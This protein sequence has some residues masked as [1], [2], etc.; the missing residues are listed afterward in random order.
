MLPMWQWSTKH[1]RMCALAVMSH[2]KFL[3]GSQAATVQSNPLAHHLQSTWVNICT[4]SFHKCVL[5]A[6]LQQLSNIVYDH[7]P[8]GSAECLSA[9]Y[10]GNKQMQKCIP[11]RNMVIPYGDSFPTSAPKSLTQMPSSLIVKCGFPSFMPEQSRY[12][13][14]QSR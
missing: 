5:S 3:A 6:F 8:E 11:L 4:H 13:G 1:Q 9:K 7:T 14:V 12:G 10:L 2:P